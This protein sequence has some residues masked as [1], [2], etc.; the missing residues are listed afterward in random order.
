[1]LRSCLKTNHSPRIRWIVSLVFVS[2]TLNVWVEP[3]MADPDQDT[4]NEIAETRRHAQA[5]YQHLN[6]ANPVSTGFNSHQLQGATSDL[7]NQNLQTL[8]QTL[9]KIVNHPLTQKLIAFTS[10]PKVTGNLIKLRNHPNLE[11]ALYFQLGWLIFFLFYRSWRG[12]KNADEGFFRRILSRLNLNIIFL[13][14]SGA[15]IP[16]LMFGDPWIEIL[17]HLKDTILMHFHS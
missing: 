9:Q 10:H 2:A 14:I 3:A 5:Q 4:Q 7:T 17:Q 8:Q 13:I 12:W 11:L 15:V 16:S 6:N 1:M